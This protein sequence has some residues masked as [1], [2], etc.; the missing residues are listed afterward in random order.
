MNGQCGSL[1]DALRYEKGIEL[2]GMDG[3]TAY[4]DARGWQTLPQDSFVQLPIP[5]RELGV[6]RRPVYSYGGPGG[7]SSAPAPDPERCPVA[8]A[9]C[10]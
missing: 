2:L 7:G 4:F 8:L 6:L 5:G 10:P 9:R 1:W 3:V